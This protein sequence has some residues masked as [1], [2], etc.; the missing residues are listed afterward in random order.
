MHGDPR[1]SI[2]GS[3]IFIVCTTDISPFKSVLLADDLSSVYSTS[4]IIE[5][6]NT[7]ETIDAKAGNWFL[8]N[9]LMLNKN[10]S[11]KLQFPS[12]NNS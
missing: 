5:L 1:G 2:L 9:N 7:V 4:N 6:S 8:V 3:L 12:I 10:K 11:Q